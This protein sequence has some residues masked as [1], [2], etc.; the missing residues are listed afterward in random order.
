M[1]SMAFA[2]NEVAGV[3]YKAATWLDVSAG[4]RYL[5][6]DGGSKTKGVEKL[7]LGGAILA[8]NIRF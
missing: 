1:V 3:A 4:Y 7:N 5:A 6:F 8:G 2:Q